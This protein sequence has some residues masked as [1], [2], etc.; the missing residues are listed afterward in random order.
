M[1]EAILTILT[2]LVLL[3]LGVAS[4]VWTL[5]MRKRRNTPGGGQLINPLA[6]GPRYRDGAVTYN[7]F[8]GRHFHIELE[9]PRGTQSAR[10]QRR[11]LPKQRKN[12]KP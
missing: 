1:M 5:F 9:D 8:N 6:G 12:T 3:T 4:L 7:Q 2:F 11:H 10:Y